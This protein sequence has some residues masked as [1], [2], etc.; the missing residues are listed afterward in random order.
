MKKL[1]EQGP[2]ENELEKARRFITGQYPLGLQAPDDLAAQL[3][4]VEFF[5]LDPTWIESFPGRVDAVTMD[6]VKRALHTHVCVSDLGILVVSDAA[7]SRKA[8][9][10]LGSIEVREP[11]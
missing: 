7:A 11:R 9:E 6:D 10:G 1:A 4:N 2:T 3:L 8:L 5:G